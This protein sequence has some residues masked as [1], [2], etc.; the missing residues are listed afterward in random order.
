MSWMIET[1]ETELLIRSVG[2]PGY[3]QVQLVDEGWIVQII[4]EY[5][6]EVETSTFATFS[7]LEGYDDD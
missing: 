3:I 5:E 6:D 2:H 7:E 4:R 1:H